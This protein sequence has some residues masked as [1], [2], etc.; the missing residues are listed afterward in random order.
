MARQVQYQCSGTAFMHLPQTQLMLTRAHA[1]Q[2][3]L[4]PSTITL[5]LLLLLLLQWL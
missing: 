3:Q 4:L 1:P 5:L 2:N